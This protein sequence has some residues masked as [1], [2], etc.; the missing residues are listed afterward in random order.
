MTEKKSFLMYTSY[1]D[2]VEI[3]SD[4]EAGQ[5][6]KA[7]YA[8]VNGNELPKLDRVVQL[9]FNPIKSHLE[10][11]MEK[12]KDICRKRSENIQKRWEKRK[13]TN[14]YNCIQTDTNYTD[15][16]N[17]NENE[18]ENVNGNVNDNKNENA[19]DNKN[20]NSLPELSLTQT[21]YE[22]LCAKY[23]KE[24]TDRHIEKVRHCARVN[25][26]PYEDAYAVIDRW[27]DGGMFG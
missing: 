17:V 8:F 14:E 22:A 5:L 1:L 10:R 7:I 27:L 18:N 3:L 24:R 9:T 25:P 15:N 6:L 13:N 4:E 26:K 12:Y 11:D 23:G 21:E 16:E 2:N 20:D 19:D